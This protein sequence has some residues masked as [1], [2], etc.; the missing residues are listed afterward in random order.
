MLNSFVD[1][2]AA[3]LCF[4]LRGFWQE[5][6]PHTELE[7]F[8]WDTMEEWSLVDYQQ[9]QPY[10]P[11]ERVFWHVL[12]QLHYW[13]EEKLRHDP[14]MVNELSNCLVFLEGK[15]V[16]PLDCVGIRP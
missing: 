5:E 15:G 8:F 12:H 4:Y 16:C 13:S 6:I 3:Q 9:D 14:T 2:K 11:K 10:T 7:I 1:T